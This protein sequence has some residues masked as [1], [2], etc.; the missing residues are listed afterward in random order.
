MTRARFALSS[1]CLRSSAPP[2]PVLS[3]VAT[4][5]VCVVIPIRP[6]VERS[7]I[8]SGRDDDAIDAVEVSDGS[9]PPSTIVGRRERVGG[10]SAGGS[11][12]YIDIVCAW[13]WLK[14]CMSRR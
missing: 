1:L 10:V 9:R 11:P 8:D 3:V 7:V 2:D 6:S 5:F 12:P 13:V 4:L 14:S